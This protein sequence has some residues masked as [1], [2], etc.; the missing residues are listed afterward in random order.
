MAFTIENCPFDASL[1]L[2]KDWLCLL[3]E[4]LITFGFVLV[5]AY[6]RKIVNIVTAFIGQYLFHNEDEHHGPFEIWSFGLKIF[7]LDIE[8]YSNQ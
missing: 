3:Q 7:N 8:T 5:I 2:K 1:D 4:R 6:Q